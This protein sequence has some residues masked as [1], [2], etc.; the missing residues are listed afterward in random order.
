MFDKFRVYLRALEPDDYKVSINWRKDN[1]I[2]DMVGGPKYFVSEAYEKKW[3]E[4]MIFNTNSV[5]LAICLKETDEYIGIG[6]ITD[7]NW[8]N[9]TAHVPSMIGEKTYW[10]QGLATEARILLLYFAFYER[11]FNRV[12]AVILEDNIA[13]QKMCEK[14]GY[15]KEGILRESVY[16]NGEMKNQ[17]LMSVLREDFDKLFNDKY[18]ILK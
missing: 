7:I 11:G 2:W 8:I 16:K 18:N 6:S 9:R 10:S 17:I 13:S 5:H 14:C 12:W 4:D 3:T 1:Q 15:K